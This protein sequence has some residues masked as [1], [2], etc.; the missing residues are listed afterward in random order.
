M[1]IFAFLSTST[2]ELWVLRDQHPSFYYFFDHVKQQ[3]IMGQ[4]LS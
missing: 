3:W 2:Y 1:I 4:P